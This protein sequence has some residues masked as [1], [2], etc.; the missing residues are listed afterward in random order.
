[1]LKKNWLNMTWTSTQPVRLYRTYLHCKFSFLYRRRIYCRYLSDS[2]RF[3]NCS[4]SISTFCHV[5]WQSWPNNMA[6]YGYTNLYIQII[7]RGRSLWHDIHYINNIHWQSY[8]LEPCPIA[9]RITD[10][11]KLD[12][13]LKINK[14]NIF[15]NVNRHEFLKY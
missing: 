1:M 9:N 7:H 10:Q 14:Q 4:V 12:N 15:H 2:C 3:L 5:V 8:W 13:G 11:N 6:E